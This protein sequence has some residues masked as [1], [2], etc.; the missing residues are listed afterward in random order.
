MIPSTLIRAG[1]LC[2][3]CAAA[4]GVLAPAA[5]QA[6]A[7]TRPVLRMIVPLPAGSTSDFVARTLAERLREGGGAPVV[8]DNRP[9][10][11][12]RIAVDALKSAPPDGAT[13]LLAPIAVP[14]VGPLVFRNQTY[15]PAK[16]LAPVAQVST[17]EFALAVAAGHPARSAPELLAWARAHP[18][19][20]SI[21]NP[22]A[23][24]LPHFLGFMLARAAGVELVQ[25]AYKSVGVLEAELMS[26]EL[27][28]GVSALSDFVALHRAGKLRV[29]ATSGE[30]RAAPLPEVA[31][32]REQGY[33]ALV[34]VGWHAVFAPAGTPTPAI[35]ELAAAIQA[36]LRAPELRAR[37]TALGL[38]PT[39]TSPQ[40]LAAIIAEDT[41]RW[42]PIVDAAGFRAD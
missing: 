23:G 19:R 32:F 9:G 12:G 16:D 17:Y 36:A 18:A 37:F 26:G 27:A 2:Q 13:V 28:S 14:V 8:I 11:S 3:L 35:E 15:D 34:V 38:E 1:I 42:R 24:S 30:K 7:R 29:L 6:Q 33:P 39:G 25:V 5:V 40:A 22:G 31:T 41:A 20:A 10:A 4:L 21:G